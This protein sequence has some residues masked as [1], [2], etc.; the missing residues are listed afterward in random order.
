MNIK[1]KKIAEIIN[2]SVSLKPSDERMREFI[3]YHLLEYF[4]REER[5]MDNKV[6]DGD[7]IPLH[8]NEDDYFNRSQFL[9]QCGVIETKEDKQLMK[10]NIKR[11]EKMIDKDC[12]VSVNGNKKKDSRY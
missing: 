1:P 3:A 5:G 9:K 8:K 11:A 2:N 4:E 6:K 12:E 10:E 7:F